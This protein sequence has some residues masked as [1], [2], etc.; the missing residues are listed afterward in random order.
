MSGR[1]SARIFSLAALTAAILSIA[2]CYGQTDLATHVAQ[3]AATLNARGTA[4]NG[5]ANVYYEYWKTSTPQTKLQTAP[6]TIPGGASGPF[7]QRVT[8]LDDQTAYSF[9]LCGG[10]QSNSG[11]A[12]CAQARSFITGSASV[13][14]YGSTQPAPFG[15]NSINQIDVN[16][17]SGPPGGSPLGR[18]YALWRYGGPGGPPGGIALNLGSQ[19]TDNITCLNVEGNVA[20]IGYRQIPPNP[21]SVPIKNV[22]HALVVDGGP[23]GSGLDRISAGATDDDEDPNDCTIPANAESS[24]YPLRSGEASVSEVEATSPD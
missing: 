3:D 20:M 14:V 22:L 1:P 24:G 2:G 6:K 18:F 10:D 23:S 21:D 13:R 19:T 8:G 5:P 4:N 12:V 15:E 7:D 16:V 9:R 11:P 17:A